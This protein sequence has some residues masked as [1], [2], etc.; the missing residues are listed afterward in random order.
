MSA[1][2]GKSSSPNRP[3]VCNNKS[4]S[5]SSGHRGHLYLYIG[6][7]RTVNFQRGIR[8]LLM[9]RTFHHQS[10]SV[11]KYIAVRCISASR[12]RSADRGQVASLGEACILKLPY[13][14]DTR[15]NITGSSQYSLHRHVPNPYTQVL[16]GQQ[17]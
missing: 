17:F 3:L 10:D 16:R 12:S 9:H 11:Q 13:L 2:H 4:S 7:L 8:I 15:R 5:M 6:N 1:V 14:S